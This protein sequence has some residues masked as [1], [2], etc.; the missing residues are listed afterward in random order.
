MM[1]I[2]ENWKDFFRE[3]YVEKKKFHLWIL[4][5][6]HRYLWEINTK[7][8][9]EE[10]EK[11]CAKYVSRFDSTFNSKAAPNKSASHPFPLPLFKFPTP[12][13][14]HPT[15]TK[16]IRPES[17]R[18]KNVRQNQSFAFLAGQSGRFSSVQ[19]SQRRFFLYLRYSLF[20]RQFLNFMYLNFQ[21]FKK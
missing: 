17:I 18:R 21:L 20:L 3:L 15:R 16:P 4:S 13:N 10:N 7:T 5:Y 8:T 12:L 6:F 1:Y 2:F 19:D 9:T 14:G 11:K